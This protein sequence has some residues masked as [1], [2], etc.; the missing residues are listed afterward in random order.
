MVVEPTSV[1]AVTGSGAD[2]LFTIQSTVA[3][4]PGSGRRRGAGRSSSGKKKSKNPSKSA[5]SR[6]RARLAIRSGDYG[7]A[8]TLIRAGLKSR[9]RKTR[10]GW[11]IVESEME[12]S[13][14]RYARAGLAAMRVVILHPK[15]EHH[16]AAL[17]WASRA[18]EGLGR[19]GKAAELYKRC[20]DHKSTRGSIRK[21]AEN[22]LKAIEAPTGD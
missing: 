14:K 19:P 15:S 6:E 12:F 3:D 21:K 17:Y 16:G 5:A 2:R 4:K 20:I 18:Y 10:D 8:G 11:R 22:R 7:L 1:A 13:R 9:N